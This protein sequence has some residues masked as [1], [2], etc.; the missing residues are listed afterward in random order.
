MSSQL[1]DTPKYT[2]A[3]LSLDKWTSTGIDCH[4]SNE[5]CSRCPIFLAYGRHKNHLDSSLRCHQPTANKI[6]IERQTAFPEECQTVNRNRPTQMRKKPAGGREV[7]EEQAVL[8]RQEIV[9]LLQTLEVPSVQPIVNKLSEAR[10][11]DREW[12][13][14]S[15]QHHIQ[16]MIAF[17][18][19]EF[20]GKK[21]YTKLYSV[22]DADKLAYISKQ[23]QAFHIKSSPNQ[24]R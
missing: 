4:L 5:D 19:I 6:L 20:S 10:F 21:G 3:F 11:L 2:N 17:G 14:N 8:L 7:S 22:I 18:V 15:I 13:Y 12:T 1:D 24:R 23:A 16:R 9:R